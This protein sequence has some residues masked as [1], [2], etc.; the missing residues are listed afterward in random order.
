[1]FIDVVPNRIM[2]LHGKILTVYWSC[3]GINPG[4]AQQ[5]KTNTR[6]HT[7]RKETLD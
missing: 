7:Q 6:T 5:Y 3:V 2:Q 4:N 1:M